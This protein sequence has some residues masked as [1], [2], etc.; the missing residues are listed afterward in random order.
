[1]VVLQMY[2]REYAKCLLILLVVFALAYRIVSD[3]LPVNSQSE[4]RLERPYPEQPT[5]EHGTQSGRSVVQAIELP[6]PP[7]LRAPPHVS[8]GRDLAN[9]STPE[10]ASR[11]EQSMPTDISIR[12]SGLGE[13]ASTEA[14]S[15]HRKA[16]E[17]LLYLAEAGAGPVITLGWPK[18]LH[19]RQRIFSTFACQGMVVALYNGTRLYRI[20]DPKGVT[21][22]IDSE[23]YSAYVRP[24]GA[25]ATPKE[26]SLVRS[27]SQHHGKVG[28]PVRVF[29]RE[30]DAILLGGISSIL[31]RGFLTTKSV[32]GLY[33]LEGDAVLVTI[34]SIDDSPANYLLPLT[35]ISN[36]CTD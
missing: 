26:A 28:A 20:G 8:T 9:N 4:T 1:M 31:G 36:A 35:R 11:V 13:M 18:D 5:V 30:L 7:P 6:A 29:R 27:L 2:N 15:K 23:Q 34:V 3:R 14:L 17:P 32:E 25:P 22:E 21:W 19:S 24:I 33:H 16:G 12:R 10:N